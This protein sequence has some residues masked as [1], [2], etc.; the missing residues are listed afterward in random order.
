MIEHPKISERE[1]L[2]RAWQRA[3]SLRDFCKK[4]GI[5]RT[6]TYGEIKAGRLKARKAG[7]RTIITEDDAEE[8]LSNLPT[9]DEDLDEAAS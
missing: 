4:Y 2:R 6:T 5:G 8:W 9:L 1:R 7:R 3:M